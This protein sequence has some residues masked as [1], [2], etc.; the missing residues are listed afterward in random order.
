MNPTQLGIYIQELKD[1]KLSDSEIEKRLERMG[2]QKASIAAP[3]ASGSMWDA[4][5]HILM[6]ISLY[7]MAC[8]IALIIHF[9]IDRWVPGISPNGYEYN[10]TGG[11]QLSLLRGYMAALIVTYPLF[12]FFFLNITRR[13]IHNPQ[14]R[15]LKSRK[16]LIYFTL[17]V[18]FLIVVANVT[19]FIFGFLNGNV[20]LNFFLHFATTVCVSSIVF[21]YYFYQIREDRTYA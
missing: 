8:T 2:W 18:T 9:F 3:K 16:V 11:W 21:G 15:Q 20:T 10:T 17:V 14:I 1:Q 6:F 5:E 7:V 4:F 19:S 13:T 12:S